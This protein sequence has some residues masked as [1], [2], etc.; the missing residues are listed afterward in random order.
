MDR[1]TATAMSYLL[2]A[3]KL[4][5]KQGIPRE[6]IGYVFAMLSVTAHST[7]VHTGA[8]AVS[9]LTAPPEVIESMKAVIDTIKVQVAKMEA[10]PAFMAKIDAKATELSLL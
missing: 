5:D 4:C 1:R 9:L 7:G 3:N 8:V 6:D 2:M 10:D